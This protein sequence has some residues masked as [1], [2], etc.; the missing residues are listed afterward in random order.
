MLSGF[1]FAISNDDLGVE[2]FNFN[3][4]CSKCIQV[5]RKKLTVSLNDIEK[6]QQCSDV[7]TRDHLIQQYL[8]DDEKDMAVIEDFVK[9]L[10]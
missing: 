2:D 1:C 9:T 7:E 5:S 4:Q 8:K 6:I 10:E 3:G